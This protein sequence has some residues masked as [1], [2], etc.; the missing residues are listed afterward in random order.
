[1]KRIAME[2]AKSTTQKNNMRT[3]AQVHAFICLM[4]SLTLTIIKTKQ[5]KM[6]VLYMR[7]YIQIPSII[8]IHPYTIH[9]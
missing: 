6:C 1:M 4:E 7:P 2:G 3:Q 9:T 8:H 5:H